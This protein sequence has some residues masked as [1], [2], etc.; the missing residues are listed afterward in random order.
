MP[1]LGITGGIG[2][3][4]S[5]FS[6]ALRQY[7]PMEIFDADRC[8][9]DL[10][11]EDAGIQRA[12]AAAFGAQILDP[13]GQPD[14]AR[15]REIIFADPA[16]RR[17]LEQI[18][19]P[20]IRARWTE[21]AQEAARGDHWFGADIPLLYETNAQSHFNAIVVVAC[22]P[23]T[24]RTR[25]L[26]LRHLPTETAEKIIATQFDLTTKI[27]QADHL[28]WND[29][30]LSSLDRQARLLAGALQALQRRTSRG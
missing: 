3:G 20:A 22:A 1:A 28:I 16:K 10:L 19:H 13:D 7:L 15:L 8:G 4:K 14:R 6:T 21:M 24:Q 17:T 9:H 29:S 30:S 11:A 18:L 27:A 12:V 25:L 23:D 26:Q 5:A 2:T